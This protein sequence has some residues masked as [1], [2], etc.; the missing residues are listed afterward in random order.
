MD[1][2]SIEGHMLFTRFLEISYPRDFAPNRA[3]LQYHVIM[4][5]S[6]TL[7]SDMNYFEAILQ[8]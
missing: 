4:N 7:N 6:K 1:L 5:D 2:A 8:H 3:Q